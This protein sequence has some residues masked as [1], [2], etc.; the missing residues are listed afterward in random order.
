V[1]LGRN[2]MTI[3]QMERILDRRPDCGVAHS[4]PPHGLCLVSV[5]YSNFPPQNG[6]AQ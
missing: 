1:D 3:D 5:T 2:R 6:E 4:L